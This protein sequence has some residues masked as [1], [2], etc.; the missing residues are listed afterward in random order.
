MAICAERF[1]E[2][3]RLIRGRGVFMLRRFKV[4]RYLSL[5][6]V[7]I[8]IMGVTSFMSMGSYAATEINVST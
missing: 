8:F 3:N 7:V 6:M 2:Q 5:V 1:K 4:K